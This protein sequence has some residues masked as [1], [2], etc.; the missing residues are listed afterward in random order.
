MIRVS[1]GTAVSIGLSSRR[2]DAFPTT[3]YLLSGE[4]CLMKCSF[5]PQ[6][7]GGLKG[8]DQLGRIT[9]PEYDWSDIERAFAGSKDKGIGRICLQSVR[10]DDG[11]E[12]LLKTVGRVKAISALPLS[13]SAWIGS[14]EEAFRMI[15]AGV[16]RIS[17]ALDVINPSRHRQIKGTSFAKRLALLLDCAEILPGR[18]N[19]HIICGLG[20]TEEEMLT[21]IGR[22]VEAG[23]TVALFAFF[24][25][26]G[27]ALAGVEPPPLDS[28]RRI[29]AGHYL[30]RTGA[31]GRSSFQ[32]AGSR[33]VS[34]GLGETDLLKHLTT[35]TAFQTSGCPDCNRPYYSERPGGV[36]YNYPRPLTRVEIETALKMV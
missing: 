32:F 12:T 3:A 26:R 33:L 36:I 2:M 13:L 4:Q 31:A 8:S 16:D 25:L 27:T 35:G 15:E 28:Y 7:A 17:I 6:G 11:I 10:H 22:L 29:Q 19:T 1:A 23:I 9:W 30:L 18:M 24:P 21:L 14:Q 20:E 5:C 34:F